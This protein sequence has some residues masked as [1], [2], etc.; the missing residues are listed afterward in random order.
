[1]DADILIPRQLK[2]RKQV[3]LFQIFKNR[4]FVPQI[5]YESGFTN[6]IH[7]D[8]TF[9]FLTDAGAKPDEKQLRFKDLNIV[10]QEL[11]FMNIPLSHYMT[12]R[13]RDITLNIPEPEAFAIHK[14]IISQRRG[15][16]NKRKKDVE[17][18]RG[19]LLFFKGKKHHIK[20]LH[21]LIAN[22]PK[23]WQEKI[24]NALKTTGLILPEINK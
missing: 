5:H 10:A 16:Q 13:Y 4:G 15:N 24:N 11:H 12:V 22:M 8:L 17:A 14:L 21:N 20:Q 23:G 1:M 2:V 3:D 18:V 7:R 6:F 9:E 19:M